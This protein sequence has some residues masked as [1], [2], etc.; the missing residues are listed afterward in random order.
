LWKHR[1]NRRTDTDLAEFLVNYTDA[2]NRR[3]KPKRRFNR[4]YEKLRGPHVILLSCPLATPHAL[5]IPARPLTFAVPYTPPPPARRPCAAVRRHLPP[6]AATCTSSAPSA[7]RL[8]SCTTCGR[9]NLNYTDSST[10]VLTEGLPR[11][12][13]GIR[14]LV[15]RVTSR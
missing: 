15:Y 1:F 8:P 3:S 7:A 14:P 9:T 11:T 2:I 4:R 13:N 6:S 10:R 5:S 12:S